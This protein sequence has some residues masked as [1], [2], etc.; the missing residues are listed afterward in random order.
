MLSSSGHS[1]AEGRACDR[2]SSPAKTNVLAT[3]PPVR[4][5]YVYYFKDIRQRA[6]QSDCVMLLEDDAVGVG[7]DVVVGLVWESDEK[8]TLRRALLMNE[9]HYHIVI[10]AGPFVY[11]KTTCISNICTGSGTV[12]VYFYCSV[13]NELLNLVNIG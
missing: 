4:A 5:E 8:G 10:G 7:D 2:D 11:T 13:N 3:T 12:R 6:L 1:S 9:I